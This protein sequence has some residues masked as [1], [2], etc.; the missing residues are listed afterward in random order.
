M[1]EE[2]EVDEIKLDVNRVHSEGCC[3]N[4]FNLNYTMTE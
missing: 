3:S 4:L 1:D 2:V